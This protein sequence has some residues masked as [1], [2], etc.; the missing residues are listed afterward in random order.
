MGATTSNA[1]REV[2][3]RFSVSVLLLFFTLRHSSDL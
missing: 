1:L 3:E 2:V